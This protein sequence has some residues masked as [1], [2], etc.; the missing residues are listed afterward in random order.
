VP[1]TTDHIRATLADHLER[2]PEDEAG[3]APALALIEA[4]ADL[5]TRAELRGHAT[6]SAILR[7]PRGEVLLIEHRSL[8]R[9]LQ[10]G[11][12]L[13]PVDTD[14]RAAALRELC[15][16]AG[17]DPAAVTSD[18]GDPIHVDCHPIPESP[19]KGEPAHFHLDFRYLFSTDLDFG[20]LQGEEVTAAAWRP[21]DEL[22][23]PRLRERCAGQSR[24]GS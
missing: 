3:L 23:D 15:E 17:I 13:E 16:E 12:H 5:T 7:N 22:A 14:L 11:G 19:A 4:G 1:I 10:P 8:R 18:G 20:T 21:V 24:T 2:H 6:A 9:W